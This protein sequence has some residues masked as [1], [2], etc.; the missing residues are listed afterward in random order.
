MSK[1]TKIMIAVAVTQALNLEPTSAALQ[2]QLGSVEEFAGN[3][4]S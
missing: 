2:I 4:E 3:I 1:E